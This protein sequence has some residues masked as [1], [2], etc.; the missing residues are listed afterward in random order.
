MG[1]GAELYEGSTIHTGAIVLPHIIVGKGCTIGAG[2][3]VMRKVKDGDTVYGNPAKVL[4][5]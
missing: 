4:R 5:L 3:V 2:S 1:G